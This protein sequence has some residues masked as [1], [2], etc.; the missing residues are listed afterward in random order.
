[1]DCWAVDR[2]LQIKQRELADYQA[3]IAAAKDKPGKAPKHSS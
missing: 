2:F 3:Q 1:V